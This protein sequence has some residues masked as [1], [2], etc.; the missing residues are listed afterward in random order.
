M[1]SSFRAALAALLALSGLSAASRPAAAAPDYPVRPIKVIYGYPAGGAGDVIGRI[2]TERMGTILGQ[3]FVME[4]RVGAGATIAASAAA[5]SDP[6]G[7]T[8]HLIIESQAISP[9][10]Y[11]NVGYD[12]DRDFAPIGMI[13][14][15]P[16]L[17]VTHKSLDVRTPADLVRLAREKPKSVTF[18]TFGPGTP[19]QFGALLL[20]RQAGIEV[21]EVPY[22]GGAPAINDLVAGHIQAFYMTQGSALPFTREGTIRALGAASAER[23]PLY[24]DLPTMREAG[25]DLQVE[26]WFGLVAPAQTPP[27]VLA[28]LQNAL[29]ETLAMPGVQ[30]RLTELGLVQTGLSGEAFRTFIRDET[31]KWSGFIRE[32][33]IRLEANR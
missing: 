3:P 19:Q 30:S 9:S 17:L 4:N 27:A 23:V 24:P 5:R 1:R 2:V 13:G 22:R 26:H 16:L 21:A 10:L 6:D 25:Y 8:I 33:G 31:R 32:N 18:A 20:A 15:S 12:T 29:A 28:A 11:P 7:Y 14:R